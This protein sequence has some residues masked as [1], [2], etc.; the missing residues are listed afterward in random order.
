LREHPSKPQAGLDWSEIRRKLAALESGASFARDATVVLDE[1]ARRL[2]RVSDGERQTTPRLELLTF[3]LTGEVYGI[4]TRYVVEVRKLRDITRVPGTP[5][6]LLGVTNLRGTILPTFDLGALLDIE[7]VGSAER[8]WLAVMGRGGVPDCG[9]AIELT[10]DLAWVAPAQLLAAPASLGGR[11]WISG[12][13]A[14]GLMV[15]D[16]SAIL[17]DRRLYLEPG[18]NQR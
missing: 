12:L 18:L 5:Q 4:E 6:H 13:T 16:G 11:T 1:R 17:D 2:A 14:E 15:L 7:Q 10:H 3:A 8:G 9:L